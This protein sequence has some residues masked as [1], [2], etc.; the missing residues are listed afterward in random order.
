MQRLIRLTCFTVWGLIAGYLLYLLL[1]GP[2]SK[3]IAL[4]A[5]LGLICIGISTYFY[6]VYIN[7]K[8][9]KRYITLIPIF[10]G[11]FNI[12]QTIIFV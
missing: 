4:H 8:G 9:K 5:S 10:L 3:N 2:G 6:T 1:G 11:L 12:T 7:V